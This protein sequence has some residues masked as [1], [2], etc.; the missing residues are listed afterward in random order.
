[1]SIMQEVLAWTQ[2]LPAWQSDAVARLPAKTALSS[3]DLDDLYALLKLSHGIA[4]EKERKPKP[5]TADQ[6]PAPVAVSSRI[7]LLAMKNLRHVNA[8]AENQRL[9]FGASGLTVIYG[10]NGSGKSGYSR[11]LKRACRARDQ[12]EAIHPNANLPTGKAGVPEAAFEICVDG[13]PEDLHWVNGKTSPPELSSIAIF[14]SRCARAYLDSEDDFSYVPYGLDVFEGLAGVCK[15]LKSRIE[16]EHAQSAVDLTAF[17]PLR[18]D[19]AV[20]KLI[21]ALSAKTTFE[22]VE[23]LATL[24]SEDHARHAELNK[25]LK[26]ADPKEKAKQLRLRARRIGGIAQN[27]FARSASV[28]LDVVARLRGLADGY[29][30]AQAAAALA[31]KQFNESEPLLPGTGGEAWREL[32][33]AARKF[34]LE[35]HSGQKFPQLGADAPCPLCQQPLAEGA[36]R[37]LRF[38]AFVQ[39]AVEKTVQERRVA[40]Y[41]EYKP[42]ADQAMS[43]ALTT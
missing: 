22:Q 17:T 36:S 3:D 41:A 34:A 6:I 28:N 31:A 37:L 19:T 5:L 12:V 14:D 24:S 32:F 43:V 27:T 29:R 39:G 10:D 20:G 23:T 25:S 26:E 13:K 9:P 35:S 15:Q 11:V 7:D 18:G 1:M 42:L 33:E 40:L 21:A 4:D 2:G 8:I 30:A 38:E 16:T